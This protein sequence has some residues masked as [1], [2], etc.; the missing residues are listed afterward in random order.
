[1][2]TEEQIEQMREEA[3]RMWPTEIMKVELMLDIR[4]L[5][6][7]ISTRILLLGEG[8]GFKKVEGS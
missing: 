2:L 1:M 5:L 3:K 7:Q 6:I 8:G 4:E